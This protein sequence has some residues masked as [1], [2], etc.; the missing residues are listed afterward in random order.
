MAKMPDD[1]Q[2]RS[3]VYLILD[4]VLL[5]LNKNREEMPLQYS[6]VSKYSPFRILL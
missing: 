6:I 3:W 5:I 2:S 4:W 1:G